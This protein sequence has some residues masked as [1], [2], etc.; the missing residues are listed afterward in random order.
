MLSLSAED[1]SLGDDFDDPHDDELRGPVRYQL[2]SAYQAVRQK[3]LAEPGLPAQPQGDTNGSVKGY[4][5]R[6]LDRQASRRRVVL[7]TCAALNQLPSVAYL[8]ERHELVRGGLNVLYARRGVGKSFVALDLALRLARTEPV[9]YVAGEGVGG[10][11]DRVAAWLNYHRAQ[12]DRFRFAAHPIALLRP[13][14]A[15][16]LIAAAV[17]I[18]PS[19]IVLDSLARCM[20]SG[21][22]NSTLDMTRFVEA[23]DRLRHTTGAAVLVVHHTRKVVNRPR[24]SVGREEPRVNGLGLG[25]A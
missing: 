17:P 2:P 20:A 22:E 24:R 9:I 14:E 4:A 19:L 11:P 21:D 1:L 12:A 7:H 18:K 10:Y 15:A 8:D 25:T 23:C 16:A 3:R 13:A 6:Y 5:G